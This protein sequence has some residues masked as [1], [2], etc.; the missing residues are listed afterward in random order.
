MFYLK[1]IVFHIGYVL[2]NNEKNHDNSIAQQH[3][4]FQKLLVHYNF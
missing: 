2:D 1:V 3:Q 4:V